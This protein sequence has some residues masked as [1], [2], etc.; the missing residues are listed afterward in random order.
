MTILSTVVHDSSTIRPT[1]NSIMRNFSLITTIPQF[2]KHVYTLIR[3]LECQSRP[4]KRTIN[5]TGVHSMRQPDSCFFV[6]P[7]RATVSLQPLHQISWSNDQETPLLQSKYNV[8]K[9]FLFCCFSNSYCVV[10]RHMY[11]T[12]QLSTLKKS[13]NE[14]QEKIRNDYIKFKELKFSSW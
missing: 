12:S 11:E 7:K 2:R 6:S 10:C 3:L 14:F 4:G 13:I 9:F 1:P 5:P 8:K